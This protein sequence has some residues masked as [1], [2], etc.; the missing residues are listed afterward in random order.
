MSEKTK[1]ERK[2]VPW[3]F[4]IWGMLIAYPLSLGPIASLGSNGYI[5]SP[6]AI[7]VIRTFYFP[8]KC[9]GDYSEMARKVLD[10]YVAIWGG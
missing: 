4:A 8:L 3:D 1:E 7:A 10:W 6:M 2:G 9:L 5:T